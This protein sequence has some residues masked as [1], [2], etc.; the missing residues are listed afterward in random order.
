[1]VEHDRVTAVKGVSLAVA[2]YAQHCRFVSQ[3]AIGT[4]RREA[5]EECL[6]D[7]Y[8]DVCPII[9]AFVDSW[10]AGLPAADHTILEPLSIA[11][12]GTRGTSE[13]ERQRGFMSADWLIRKCAP[14]W[15]TVAGLNSQACALYNLPEIT[16]TTEMGV[17]R[18]MLYRITQEA[19][20]AAT[21][22]AEQRWLE[23]SDDCWACGWAAAHD[24]ARLAVDE[25]AWTSAAAATRAAAGLAAGA[26][27]SPSVAALQI[28]AATL[29]VRMA[30]MS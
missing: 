5:I 19:Y 14:T 3:V 11:I 23:A 22:V 12:S 15:L 10:R 17:V 2:A 8:S 24:A 25:P 13:T 18:G 21:C 20:A 9:F 30:S 6:N 1:M 28:S 26:A 27:R 4:H 16:E 7:Q 29:V